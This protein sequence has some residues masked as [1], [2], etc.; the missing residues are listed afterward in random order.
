MRGGLRRI[1]L[2]Q[3]SLTVFLYL[4]LLKCT[5]HVFQKTTN[6]GVTFHLKNGLSPQLA[7]GPFSL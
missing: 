4:V 6:P 2:S 3:G 7:T 1:N 5:L